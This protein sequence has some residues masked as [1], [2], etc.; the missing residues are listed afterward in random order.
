MTITPLAAALLALVL[1]APAPE[2]PAVDASAALAAL[3]ER[4]AGVTTPTRSAAEYAAAADTYRQILDTVGVLAADDPDALS[5][6]QRIDLELLRRHAAT[7]LFEIEDARLHQLVPVNYLA[8]YQTDSLMLRPCGAGGEAVRGAIA[9]LHALPRILAN[10]RDNLLASTANGG[11]GPARVWTENALATIP[12]AVELLADE[13][14]GICLADR[15]LAAELAAAAGPALEA[16]RG[17][18]R[19]LR[20]TLLPRSR[21]TPAWTPEQVTHYQLVHEGLAAYDVDRM[22][23]IAEAEEARLTA[24]MEAL[25]GRI[26]PSGDLVTVWELMKD[27]APPW[28]EVRPMAEDYVERA[29]T[30]LEGDGAH[31]VEIPE[32]LDYGVAITSPMA[33]RLLSFGGASYG[34]TIGGRISGYYVLTP[35]PPTLTEDE[36]RSRLRSYNPYWT[37]VISYHEWL[38]HNVQRS[39]AEAHR[40]ESGSPMRSLFRS[41]Y[42]SQAWSFYL[43]ALLETEG[44]YETLPHMERL[45]TAMARRQMRMWRVQRI[46]TKL[47]MARGEMT[48]DQAVQAY[49]DKIGME[50]GNA[51]VEVQRDSQNPSPPGREIIGEL[52][53]FEL[54]DEYR[55]RM[56]EHY[57][58]RAF[59]EALLR[60]G[61]LPLDIVGRLIFGD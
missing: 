26:H 37:H 15:A 2:P 24:E 33:R 10:G 4:A 55:R 51:F 61:E 11:T 56:G 16:V 21:R 46:L 9:E 59:H 19:W 12:H 44:Y 22:I 48:F 6:D 7:G 29:A 43:E 57:D 31:L 60:W 27:E 38:G 28:D 50:P 36:R 58:P 34:P 32:E 8:L 54:R 49:V 1:A 53:I 35:P 13:V 47:E 41:S 45:K 3:V 52:A 40:A 42:L 25:A 18:E 23:E 5:F 20:E 17:Y 30:W 14:P 39:V